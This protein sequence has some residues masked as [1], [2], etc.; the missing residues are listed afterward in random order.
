MAM[1]EYENK[2]DE[3]IACCFSEADRK[4]YEALLSG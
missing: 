2:F 4:M 1:R 3:I